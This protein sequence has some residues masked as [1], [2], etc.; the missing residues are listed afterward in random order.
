[1]FNDFKIFLHPPPHGFY[2][3][4]DNVSG[5]VVF[6]SSHD[7]KAGWVYVFFHGWVNVE[8]VMMSPPGGPNRATK[9]NP[10]GQKWSDKSR[11]KEILF[12]S[13]LKVYEGYDKLRKKTRYEWPF[14]FSF[15]A[16]TT[17]AHGLPSSGHYSFLREGN[18]LSSVKYKVV[19]VHGEIGQRDDDIRWMLNPHDPRYLREPSLKPTEIFLK[20][21]EK[22]GGATEQE[23]K[24]VGIRGYSAIDPYMHP[25]SRWELY[26]EGKHV[27]QLAP[28]AR[29][30]D[31]QVRKTTFPFSVDLQMAANI[32]IGDPFMVLLSVSSS[33][34]IW[35]QNPPAVILKSFKITCFMIDIITIGTQTPDEKLKFHVV[36]EG[37]RLNIPLSSNPVDIGKLYSFKIA[38]EDIAQSFDTQTLHRAYD[39]PVELTVEV[40]GKSFEARYSNGR[41]TLLSP[42]VATGGRMLQAQPSEKFS[43]DFR[44]DSKHRFQEGLIK[45]HLQGTYIGR[46]SHDGAGLDRPL[47]EHSMMEAAI[48][49]SRTLTE[50]GIQHEFPGGTMI[51][52]FPYDYSQIAD[53]KKIRSSGSDGENLRHLFE[54]SF[55][56]MGAEERHPMSLH[57]GMTDPKHGENISIEFS[58]KPFVQITLQHTDHDLDLFGSAELPEKEKASKKPDAYAMNLTP[59]ILFNYRLWSLA[60]HQSLSG[61]PEIWDIEPLFEAFKQNLR[62]H[63]KR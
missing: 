33:S 27:P 48:A 56:V 22:L 4:E 17:S 54:K 19:A 16:E 21:K 43:P 9:N 47:A 14:S 18:W 13:H 29:Y 30:D 40:G 5:K 63:R 34:N 45:V 42:I 35:N 51:K 50:A 3:F 46:L 31:L 52:L 26:I 60:T 2:T 36:W 10:Y 1:M 15:Q 57:I 41:I 25:T 7:E 6:E 8:I 28:P 53:D 61:E 32:V 23:L 39:F 12:Q 55:R 62:V 49:L 20:I 38:G 24:F 37:K 11:D 58:S 44:H 59:V